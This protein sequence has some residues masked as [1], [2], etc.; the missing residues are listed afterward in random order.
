M[1]WVVGVFTVVVGAATLSAR[2]LRVFRRALDPVTVEAE[3]TEVSVD[4]GLELVTGAACGREVVC[5]SVGAG[6]GP[7]RGG[8][9]AHVVAADVGGRDTGGTVPMDNMG[10]AGS[11]ASTVVEVVA[12]GFTKEDVA[13]AARACLVN[14]RRDEA[15]TLVGWTGRSCAVTAA[16]YEA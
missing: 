11:V 6:S 15:L 2:T 10:A 4:I 14:W 9:N 16:A 3:V 8:G 13:R 7:L 12:V 1:G 5:G